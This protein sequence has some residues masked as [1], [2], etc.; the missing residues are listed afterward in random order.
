LIAAARPDTLGFELNLRFTKKPLDGLN[1]ILA[2]VLP[3]FGFNK[4]GLTIRMG[5]SDV[6]KHIRASFP[7]TNGSLQGHLI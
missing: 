4:W 6:F 7:G 3:H 5:Y 2:T 1:R